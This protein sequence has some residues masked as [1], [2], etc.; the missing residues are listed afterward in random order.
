MSGSSELNTLNE[1]Q[2]NHASSQKEIIESIKE[3]PHSRKND[4]GSSAGSENI[5]PQKILSSH[6][7]TGLSSQMPAT[8]GKNRSPSAS[9]VSK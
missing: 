7:N 5:Y 2:E 8:N 1:D 6:I 3:F 9:T 4:G